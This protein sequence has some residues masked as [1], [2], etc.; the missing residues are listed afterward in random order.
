MNNKNSKNSYKQ[1]LREKHNIP[2]GCELLI[3][4]RYITKENE[5]PNIIDLTQRGKLLQT[6]FKI[7]KLI[8]DEVKDEVLKIYSIIDRAKENIEVLKIQNNSY[9][10]N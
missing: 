3:K 4:Q 6:Q 10:I 8:Y 1:H 5:L 7:Y 2:D 9:A